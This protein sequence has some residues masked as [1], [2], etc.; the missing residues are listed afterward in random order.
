M[1]SKLGKIRTETRS[2]RPKWPIIGHYVCNMR[3]IWE[4]GPDSST[5]TVECAVSGRDIG[6]YE[7]FLLDQIQNG[8]PAATSDRQIFS[9]TRFTQHFSMYRSKIYTIYPF[10]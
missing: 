6:Y 5:I 10:H 1:I 9:L 7:K 8:R 2:W 3:N 4:T